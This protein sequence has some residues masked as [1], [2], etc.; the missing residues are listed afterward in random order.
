MT[1]EADDDGGQMTTARMTAAEADDTSRADA[2]QLFLSGGLAA[3]A[4]AG[5][6]FSAT[7]SGGKASERKVVH[8]RETTST[9]LSWWRTGT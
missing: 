8:A 3:S 9:K 4:S 5:G 2:P 7:A 1:A 6:A